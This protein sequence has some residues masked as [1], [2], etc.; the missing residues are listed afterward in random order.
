MPFFIGLMEHL[1]KRGRHL[2][3]TGPQPRRRGAGQA[4]GTAGGDRH[5]SRRPLDAAAARARHCA[6]VGEALGADAS[7]RREL[8]ACAAP[9]RCR[10]TA[11]RRYSTARGRAPTRSPRASPRRPQ[12]S[13][14]RCRRSGRPT[15]RAASSMPISFPTTSSFS[16]SKLSG[17]IDFYFACNDALAYDLA[18]CLNAWCFEPDSSFNITKGMALINGYERVRKLGAARGRGACR[19]WRAARLCASC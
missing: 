3:A 15:C 5:L 14:P 1:A 19:C 7:R 16:A 11:G 4:R 6:A 12:P 2:P 9:T 13:S 17:L 10:S 8:R 18:I